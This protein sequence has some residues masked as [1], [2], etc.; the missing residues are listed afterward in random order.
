[1]SESNC[2]CNNYAQFT[3]NSGVVNI[4]TANSNL[5]GTGSTTLV[6]TAGASGAMLKSV[7]I[8]ATQPTT[9]GMVR[10]YV[11]DGTNRVLFKEIP[12]PQSPWINSF[13]IQYPQPTS[14][15]MF[16]AYIPCDIFLAPGDKLYA[17]TQN[18]ESFNI[19]AEAVDI[20][21]AGTIPDSCCNFQQ[22][23]PRTGMNIISTANTNLNGSGTILPIFNASAGP[24]GYIVKSIT[25]EA[26]QSTS[27]GVVRLF[28]SPNGGTNYYL[29]NEISIPNTTSSSNKPALKVVIPQFYHLKGGYMLGAS[30]QN[31]E[32]FGIFVQGLKWNY[33]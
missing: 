17:S 9:Q 32:S 27:N 2:D 6:L 8:K 21:Y 11:Y 24:N 7:I 30:T 22:E 18:A 19:I 10:L 28:I 15:T 14:L 25:I 1:M 33:P 16:V 12:V 31:A 4:S 3:A 23:F 13:P 26:L 29:M 20:S 5:N